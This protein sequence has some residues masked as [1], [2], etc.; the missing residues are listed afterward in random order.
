MNYKLGFVGNKPPFGPGRTV[1]DPSAS[2]APGQQYTFTFTVTAPN[3]LGT[4]TM[5]YRVLREGVA[6]L[7]QT[8]T[9][10]IAVQ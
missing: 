1:L 10:T 7:G 2:V 9:T 5:Q 8:T 3:T 4:Y 6:W